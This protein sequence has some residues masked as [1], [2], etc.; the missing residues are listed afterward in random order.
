M[1]YRIAQ[2][3]HQ[4]PLAKRVVA[5]LVAQGVELPGDQEDYVI[6]RTGAGSGQKSGGAWVWTL[7]YIGYSD[8]DKARA[9]A[10]SIGSCWPASNFDLKHTKMVAQRVVYSGG[11][12]SGDIEVVPLQI[13]R[14]PGRR[15]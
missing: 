3:A 12:Q 13:A 7:D 5:K 1:N 8:R 9:R 14:P 10:W 4:T 6:R 11:T 15:L 2:I